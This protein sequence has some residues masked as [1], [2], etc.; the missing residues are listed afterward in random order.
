M[1]FKTIMAGAS[2]ESIYNGWW[3]IDYGGSGKEAGRADLSAG[4]T[5]DLVGSRHPS[6]I[7]PS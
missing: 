3:S 2:M 5:H 6:S 7:N 4:Q 1:F